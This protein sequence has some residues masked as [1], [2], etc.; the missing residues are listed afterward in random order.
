MTV[1]VGIIGTGGIS[2]AHQ[3]YY[4]KVGGFEIVAVCDI[5][6]SKANQAADEWGVSRKHAFSS[7]NKM[8]EMDEIEAVS[9]CTY[10]QGH[11]RPTVAALNAG[12]HVL[13]EKPMAATLPDATAMVRAAKA[14]GKILQIGLNPTFAP[15]LQFARKLIDEGLLG[16]IYYSESAGGRRRGNPGHTFIYK[17]TAGAGAIVDIGVYNMHRSLYAMGYPKPMR[18]SAI[19]EDYISQQDPRFRGIM[20]VEEFGVAWIR[21]EDGSVMVFKISWAIHQ[22]SLGTNFHLGTKA[23]ISLDGPV[24]YADEYGGELKKLVESEGLTAE[25]NPPEGMTTIQLSGFPEVDAWELQMIAFREAIK[26]DAPSP[27]PPEGVLLTNVIMDGIFRS[28]EAGKEVA[29]RVPEI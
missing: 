3:R 28:H 20:D 15:S 19:T 25:P 4:E 11:R 13:C 17:K 6:K 14:S 22:D 16:D 12:K 10:N 7:Y 24:I 8:L 27:I 21:F 1:R 2:R 29:V 26:S 9:V 23:G 18:V 5:I